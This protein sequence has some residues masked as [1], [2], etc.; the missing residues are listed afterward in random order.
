MDTAAQDIWS[1]A[2][3]DLQVSMSTQHFRMW[4]AG[5][6]LVETREVGDD[7]MIGVI[8]TPSAMHLNMIEGRFYATLKEALDHAS[9]KKFDIQF[10]VDPTLQMTSQN[11]S[12]GAQSKKQEENKPTPLFSTIPTVD[13]FK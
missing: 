1:K 2:T 8:A 3:A 10:K 12:P 7:H 13:A 9:G 5:S 4:I 6:S 11:T